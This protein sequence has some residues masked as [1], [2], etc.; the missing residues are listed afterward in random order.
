MKSLGIA[1]YNGMYSAIRFYQM[2]Q[3]EEINPIIGVEL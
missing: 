3:E 2:A 1:D